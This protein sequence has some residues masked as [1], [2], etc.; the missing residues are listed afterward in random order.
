MIIQIYST[1]LGKI[2]QLNLFDH[3]WGS[4]GLNI[5]PQISYGRKKGE[6]SSFFGCKF[7]I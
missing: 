6:K 3:S 4:Y 7:G 5:Q 1:Y 2:Q